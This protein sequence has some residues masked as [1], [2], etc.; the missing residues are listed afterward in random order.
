MTPRINCVRNGQIRAAHQLNF[1]RPAKS[2]VL[3]LLDIV[4]WWGAQGE[5]GEFQCR[6]AEKHGKLPQARY[7]IPIKV[8][9]RAHQPE[10]FDRPQGRS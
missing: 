8:D 6:F 10:A 1:G 7:G 5:R 9:K 4:R 2:R 3:Y